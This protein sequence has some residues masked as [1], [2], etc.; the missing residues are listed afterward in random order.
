MVSVYANEKM[1]IKYLQVDIMDMDMN[2]G[3]YVLKHK[4]KEEERM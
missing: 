4:E 2:I 3:T 1:L